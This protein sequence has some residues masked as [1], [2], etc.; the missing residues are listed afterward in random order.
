MTD[1]PLSLGS[2]DMTGV[3][4]A[5]PIMRVGDYVFI[6][7]SY[8]VVYK[9]DDTSK[10]NLKVTFK[11]EEDIEAQV[12]PTI[13]AGFPIAVFFPLQGSEKNPEWDFR[14]NIGSMLKAFLQIEND[15]DIPEL[16]DEVMQQVKGK[17][18]VLRIGI[19]TDEN[20]N[21]RNEVKRYNVYDV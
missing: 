5:M 9:K 12:G 13:K 15:S 18:A 8:E 1:E 3:S 16:S 14:S 6:A 7:D 2:I 11:S 19:S 17:K 21:E 4:T 10:K 20:D